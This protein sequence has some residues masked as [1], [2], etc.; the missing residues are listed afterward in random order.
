[1][2]I[3]MVNEDQQK[4][5]DKIKNDG[6]YLETCIWYDGHIFIPKE[7]VNNNGS[8]VI[9]GDTSNGIRIFQKDYPGIDLKNL[10]SPKKIVDANPREYLKKSYSEALQNAIKDDFPNF[11]S[12]ISV[13]SE[14]YI[15]FDPP[16]GDEDYDGEY[17]DYIKTYNNSYNVGFRVHYSCY[18]K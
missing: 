18:P 14:G 17:D 12:E 16:F 8:F 4:F 15:Q 7:E 1:M 10:V 11:N 13:D 2:V 5:L 6:R 9:A 3:K